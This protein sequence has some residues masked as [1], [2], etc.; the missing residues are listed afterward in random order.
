MREVDGVLHDVA[1]LFEVGRDVHG[2]IGHQQRPRIARHVHQI[3]MAEPAAGAQP[4]VRR[5]HRV[6][7]FVG[8]QR[9]LH[10]Q[11]GLAPFDQ[12]DG[13][14]RRGLAVRRVDQPE[15]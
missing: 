4:A 2:R 14:G 12:R 5:Q 3:D 15:R 6:E 13:L 7:Q 10:Q 1:L 9:A 8:M 11:R